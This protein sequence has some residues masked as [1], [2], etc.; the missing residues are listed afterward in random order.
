MQI[1][2]IYHINGIKDK[3]HM[4]I[5][6]NAEKTSDQI[7]PSFMIKIYIYPKWLDIEGTHLKI[8]EDV[9]NKPTSQSIIKGWKLSF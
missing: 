5:S 8:I 1:N 2:V 4:I 7:Q 6:I 3:I 9:Y